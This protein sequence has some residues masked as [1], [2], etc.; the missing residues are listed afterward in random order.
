MCP[1]PTPVPE[2]PLVALP[3]VCRS[4]ASPPEFPALTHP[5]LTPLLQCRFRVPPRLCSELP[6]PFRTEGGVQIPALTLPSYGRAT[7]T[8][9]V[10]VSSLGS[11]LRGGPHHITW[12]R[13]R[14]QWAEVGL[15]LWPTPSA[16]TGSSHLG[17]PLPGSPGSRLASSYLL[18]RPLPEKATVIPSCYPS[19]QKVQENQEL[20]VVF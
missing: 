11:W 17:H 12:G 8:T 1:T 19:T 9:G 13:G 16:N 5:L 2:P 15:V 14:K 18:F 10:S 20:K 3:Q 6:M 7:S 4:S